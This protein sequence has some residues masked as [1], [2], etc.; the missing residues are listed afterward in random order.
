MLGMR[1]GG[2]GIDGGDE[3]NASR[4]GGDMDCLHF[5]LN[6]SHIMFAPVIVYTGSIPSGARSASRT[7]TCALVC[8]LS[9][10][11]WP[12]FMPFFLLGEIS[13]Y[14]ACPV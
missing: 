12:V 5:R 2:G 4:G 6:S 9:K 13:R 1:L 10:C 14:N 8:R 7:T 3:E 11:R